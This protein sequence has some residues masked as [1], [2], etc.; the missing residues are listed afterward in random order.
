MAPSNRTC[1][2]PHLLDD[3]YLVPFRGHIDHRGQCVTVWRER[4]TDNGDVS[5]RE[6]AAGH[7]HFGLHG[8]ETGWILREWLPNATGVVLVGEFCNWEE[9][10]G[11]PFERSRE[12]GVWECRL[13]R[14]ALHH[15]DLFR[16]SVYWSGGRGDRIPAYANRVVQDAETHIFNAQVWAPSQ[17]YEWKAPTPSRPPVQPLVYEAHVGIAQEKAAVGT[18]AEFRDQTLPRIVQAGYNTVQLMAVMEH[19]YYGSFGYHV[20]S[21]FAASSRFGTPEELKSLIDRA[22]ELGLSVIMDLVHSHA[23]KNDVEGLSRMDG[24]EYQ[25]FHEG[26]RGIHPV[27]D[28]RCFDYSRP[29]VM[30]FLLSNCRFWLEEFHVDGFRFDGIT[31]MLYTHHGLGT[32]FT[33]YDQYFDDSVDDDALAYL[34]LANEL[35]H[36][37][38][39]QAI[40]IAEDVSGIPGLAAPPSAGGCGFDYRL[41]MG[42]PDFWFKWVTETPDEHWHMTYLWHELTNRRDDERTISY[43]ESHDQA[44]VGG[45]TFLFE[46]LDSAMYNAMHVDAHGP[47]VDRGIALHKL[48]RMMTALTA[49]H[50]YLT[51]MGNE[52][53]HPEWIDFPREGNGWSY[54]H[55]RRRWSLRENA[56]L[57]YGQLAAFDQALLRLV[58]D[59]SCLQSNPPRLLL[60]DDNRHVLAFERGGLFVFANLHPTE[61]Y[62]DLSVELP[63]PGRLE[64]ALDSDAPAFGGQGRIA[65]GQSYFTQP[66]RDGKTLRHCVHLYLPCRTALVLRMGKNTR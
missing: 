14:E 25:Y 56:G 10:R 3:P 33:T 42:L 37:V 15:G 18:Y 38:A 61:S 13:P 60:A 44:I 23:V 22:H 7:L 4:L 41:A 34:A 8:T 43:V 29:E 30:H 51:F 57:K 46:M 66:R 36:S 11:H 26:A 31:S 12:D 52:F 39:P 21:F 48:A 58:E 53:G 5:L 65:A 59:V 28:S 54:E 19:P 16:L 62:Q 2:T 9:S 55:A 45:K 32:V 50:G 63:A 40:T 20:S 24:S 6:F 47:V 27:W 17:P 35:I 64:P 49:G 1:T